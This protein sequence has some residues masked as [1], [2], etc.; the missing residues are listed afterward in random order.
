MA[1][2]AK[3]LMHCSQESREY[4]FLF[5]RVKDRCAFTNKA[6]TVPM[7]L[8]QAIRGKRQRTNVNVFMIHLTP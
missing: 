6:D 3:S 7:V 8:Y 2:H 5:V 4:T 1:I